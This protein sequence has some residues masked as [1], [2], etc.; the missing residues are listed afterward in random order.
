MIDIPNKPLP[1]SGPTDA[2]SSATLAQLLTGGFEIELG[3]GGSMKVGYLGKDTNGNKLFGILIN[4][5]TTNRFF[6][7]FQSGG[8]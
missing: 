7:G 2:L 5:G 8:F 6:M 1:E 3:D 4:D